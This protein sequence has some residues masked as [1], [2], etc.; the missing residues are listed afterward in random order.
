MSGADRL[1]L[2]DGSSFIH[3]AYHAIRPLS[4]RSGVPTNAVFGYTSMLIKLL[5]DHDPTHLAVAFDGPVKGTFRVDLYPDYKAH[6]PPAPEDL[7]PQ[8]DLCRQ[9]TSAFRIPALDNPRVEADDI[10]ATLSRQG[11]AAGCDVTIVSSDKDLMQLVGPRVVLLDSMRDTVYDEAAVQ[12]KW[13]VP[14]DKILDLLALMGDSSD[15][16]PGVSGIGAKTAAT[17]LE[18]HGNLEGVLAAAPGIKGKRGKTLVEQADLARLSA[19]LVA[20][21]ESVSLGVTLED[22]ARKEPDLEAVAAL[23]GEL[24]FDRMLTQV[25]AFVGGEAAEALEAQT[26][27]GLDRERYETLEDLARLDEVLA[28]AVKRGELAIDLETTSLTP[29]DADIVGFALCW[30]PGEAGYVPVGHRGLAV[31]PQLEREVVLERLRPLLEGEIPRLHMQNHKY[32]TAVFRRYGVTL[33]GVGC[34]PM[35]ASYLLDPSASSHGLDALALR[36][37]DH[38]MITFKEVCGTGKSQ[39]TFDEVEIPVATRYAGEDAEATFLLAQRLEP[40][41]HAADL[42]HLMWDVEVPLARVLAIMEL[43][44]VKLDLPLL[45]RLSGEM[46]H[47]LAVLEDE[48]ADSAGMRVNLNSPK[49]LQVLLFEH[50]GL[51]PLRKTKTGYSTDAEVL[52]QLADEHEVAAKIHEYRQIQKLKGTYVDALPRMVSANT[53]RLHTSYNQAVAATGRLSSSDPNLQNI[54]IR[55]EL[56]REI[57]RAFIAPEGCRL[58][59]ADYSQIELRVL[60]HLAGDEVLL[61]SFRKGEDI[62]TRTAAEV[63]EVFPDTVDREQRRVAKA[64]NFGVIYGQSAFGLSRQLKIARGVA[65]GYIDAYFQRY[66]GVQAYMDRLIEEARET[67]ET[68]TILGRRRPLPDLNSRNANLRNAAERMVR[69]TPIQGS[70]ADIIKLAMLRCQA[71]LEADFPNARMLLTV[72]DELVFEVPEG[73]TEALSDAVREEMTAA[74]VLDAPLVVDIGVGHDWLEAH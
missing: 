10:I 56:G 36:E 61:E 66:R 14:P 47:Q 72:H 51:K 2:V 11:E 59:A 38:K 18:K 22:L 21:D 54:P 5:S 62:H 39:R 55:T 60:A 37:L 57:R 31:G 64:V 33:R 28:L 17:L 69:N 68:T 24:D 15:N 70:A 43:D 41:V 27:R 9:V 71:R 8:F 53:G 58:V 3:R 4:S 6:R 67:G 26:P 40:R 42:D 50:L 29:A 20:L 19:R 1:Y 12:K 34:D 25:R 73:E 32:E 48:V 52:A 74:Y 49:Q 63:F 45:E 30:G 35:I 65:Q 46:T 44:G 13:G 23:F 7:V 16:I